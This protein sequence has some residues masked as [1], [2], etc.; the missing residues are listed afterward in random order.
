MRTVLLYAGIYAAI[1]WAAICEQEVI[2]RF[3]TISLVPALLADWASI[4]E[5]AGTFRRPSWNEAVIS[6]QQSGSTLLCAAGLA[7]V[8]LIARVHVLNRRALARRRVE[9]LRNYWTQ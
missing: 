2:S 5:L 8:A 9:A 4:Q 1:G 6:F 7:A 3:V